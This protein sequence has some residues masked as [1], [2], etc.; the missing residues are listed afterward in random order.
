MRLIFPN[1]KKTAKLKTTNSKNE[2]S[3]KKI[4]F[5]EQG[6]QRL[7]VTN[8]HCF[9]NH[10]TSTKEPQK[11]LGNWLKTTM[12]RFVHK[13]TMPSVHLVTNYSAH[14]VRFHGMEDITVN[15]FNKEKI[16]LQRR[17]NLPLKTAMMKRRRRRNSHSPLIN[18][19]KTQ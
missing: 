1:I 16:H 15:D 2:E 11:S 12:E 7:I 3:N 18:Q 8:K 17:E 5:D 13:T 9:S 4:F 10:I 14:I 19:I 6:L